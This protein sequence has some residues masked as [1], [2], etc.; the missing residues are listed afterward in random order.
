[1]LVFAR[2]WHRPR[3]YVKYLVSDQKCVSKAAQ[4]PAEEAHQQFTIARHNFNNGQKDKIYD[5][6]L[7]CLRKA[8]FDFSQCKPQLK[9]QMDHEQT[10]TRQERYSW[11]HLLDWLESE[12]WRFIHCVS[13]N[14]IAGLLALILFATLIRSPSFVNSLTL[15]RFLFF[16]SCEA[17]LFCTMSYVIVYVD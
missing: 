16:F 17:L 15:L 1:M 10:V 3:P 5:D 4:S 2:R 7:V 12:G 13:S 14:I 6:L 9:A 8:H 11:K